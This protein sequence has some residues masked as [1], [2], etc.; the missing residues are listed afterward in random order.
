LVPLEPLEQELHRDLKPHGD[1]R[2]IVLRVEVLHR[3]LEPARVELPRRLPYR[4]GLDHPHTVAWLGLGLGLGLG[5]GLGLGLE[6]GLRPG[7]GPG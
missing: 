2:L 1:G 4:D 6:L 7:L 3:T 5:S